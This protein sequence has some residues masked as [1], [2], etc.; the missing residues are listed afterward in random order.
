M[1]E[2]DESRRK[3]TSTRSYRSYE[4][5]CNVCTDWRRRIWSPSHWSCVFCFWS[6][7][8]VVLLQSVSLWL[9]HL[10]AWCI[11]VWRRCKMWWIETK[12]DVNRIES[13]KFLLLYTTRTQ[14]LAEEHHWTKPGHL[15]IIGNK[16]DHALVSTQSSR[17]GLC[18]VRFRTARAWSST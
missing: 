6:S 18:A 7:A 2:I 15:D 9:A 10:A 16:R 4:I 3:E 13:N 12:Y 11:L 14:P 8:R 1:E 5:I 17:W